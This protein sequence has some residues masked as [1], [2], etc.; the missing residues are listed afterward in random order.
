[1]LFPWNNNKKPYWTNPENGIAWFK[2][3][4]LT[5]Y[6]Q[7]D[8]SGQPVNG[9]AFVL[10]RKDEAENYKPITRMFIDV[11]TNEPLFEDSSLEGFSA[12]IDML[13]VKKDFED[14][15]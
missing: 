10:A 14:C 12:K 2:D 7:S 5:K 6:A 1:M 9:M 4:Q 11:E 15:E 3:E 13:K 8:S